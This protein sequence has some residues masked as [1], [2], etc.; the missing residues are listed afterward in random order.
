MIEQ[1]CFVISFLKNCFLLATF[2]MCIR[3]SAM[4]GMKI[5]LWPVPF[6]MCLLAGCLGSFQRKPRG[7]HP[8]WIAS[9]ISRIFWEHL[10]EREANTRISATQSWELLALKWE[11]IPFLKRLFVATSHDLTS[12]DQTQIK[13][14]VEEIRKH[15]TTSTFSANLWGFWFMIVSKLQREMHH[16]S[17]YLQCCSPHLPE[18]GTVRNDD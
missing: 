14:Q 17:S 10:A 12:F 11:W 15:Q 13:K 7:K 1:W 3:F 4:N 2:M 8:I 18:I 16:P 9:L 6:E 5:V